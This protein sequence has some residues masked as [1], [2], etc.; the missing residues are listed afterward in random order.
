[1]TT[2]TIAHIESATNERVGDFKIK[3]VLPTRNLKQVDP[4]LL[5]HHMSPFELK[6][7]SETRLPPHPHAGFE[8]ATYL[9]DGEFFHRDSKGHNQTAKAGDVNWMVSGAGILHSEGPT[10][11]LL[12]DGGIVQLLQL[13]INLPADKKQLASAFRHYAGETMPL[14][15]N[16]KTWLKVVIGE[17]EGQSSPISTHT[18][19]FLYHVK[20]K[21]GQLMTIPVKENHSAAVYIMQGKIKVLNKEPVAGELINFNIDGNQLVFTATADTELII[22]GGEPIKEKVVSYGPFV[23]NSFE[24][25]QQAIAD[26]ETGKMGVL[27]Y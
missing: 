4:F 1:M 18:P 9:L 22:L 14:I 21:K 15:E 12:K 23:M 26:Y 25:I 10:E 7:G 17:Y 27:E 13:W 5:I 16:E 3:N 19:V 2:R 11:K 6:P 20:I 8:V 24:E